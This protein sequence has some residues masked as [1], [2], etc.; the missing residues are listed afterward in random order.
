VALAP[1]AALA[2]LGMRT[3]SWSSPRDKQLVFWPLASLYAYVFVT[4]SWTPYFLLGVT[5]PLA[6]LAVRGAATLPRISVRPIVVGTAVGLLTLPGVVWLG[7]LLRERST[8]SARDV[9]LLKP[10]DAHALDYVADAPQPGSVLTAGFLAPAAW[11]LTGRDSWAA[12]RL[13]DAEYAFGAVRARD[14]IAGRLTARGA[15][16]FV[17]R[18]QARFVVS[19]CRARGPDLRPWLGPLVARTTRFGC[20]T[21]YE[22]RPR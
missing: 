22:L 15:K 14:L 21:V 9:Y 6:I 19:G 17:T 5:L 11:A 10:G 2:L 20:A 18:T 3:L 4:A 12:S 7:N 8:G 16:L 13:F 1:L